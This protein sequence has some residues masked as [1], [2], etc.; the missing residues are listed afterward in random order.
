MSAQ[1]IG[2]KGPVA[3]ARFTLPPTVTTLGADPFNHI[4]WRDDQLAPHHARIRWQDGEYVIEDLESD[5]GTFVNGSRIASPT[6][7]RSGD[8]LRIGESTWLFV[9]PTPSAARVLD[10]PPRPRSDAVTSAPASL[11]DEETT[12]VAPPGVIQPAQT[13][14]QRAML[15]VLL[16]ALAILAAFVF[17]LVPRL[18]TTFMMSPIATFTPTARPSATATPLPA[19]PTWTTAPETRPGYYPVPIPI[20]P[21]DGSVGARFTLQWSWRGALAANEWYEVRAWQPGELPR[22]LAW[23]KVPQH[24]IGPELPPG[25]Y[26]WQVGVVQGVV[27]GQKQ[28]DLSA[29]SEI[30]RLT[31]LALTATLTPR[32][33]ATPT[34]PVPTATAT[35]TPIPLTRV[36]FVGMIYDLAQGLLAPVPNAEIRIYVADQRVVTRA[37]ASGR[38]SAEFRLTGPTQGQP[39]SVLVAAPGY[40]PGTRDFTLGALDPNMPHYIPLDIGLVIAPTLTPTWLPPTATPTSLPTATRTLTH[41]PPPT[42]TPPPTALPITLTPTF[43]PGDTPMPTTITPAPP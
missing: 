27:P 8:R 16:A 31:L 21:P 12:V 26:N 40:Q 34:T 28:R 18:W 23:V 3:G 5:S 11:P 32:P 1:L 38:Y 43:V 29:P 42:Y 9:Q 4:T 7:L 39:V 19:L 17:L 15:I 20:N 13:R 14:Q 30:R 35:N 41:T 2:R 10:A 37:D 24:E 25:S 6:R 36:I 22:V 33:T